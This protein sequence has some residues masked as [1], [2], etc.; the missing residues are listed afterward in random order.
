MTPNLSG[1]LLGSAITAIYAILIE[2]IKDAMRRK[3]E[4]KVAQ[5]EIYS[6]LADYLT[7]MKRIA[8]GSGD[9]DSDRSS[10]VR[11]PRFDAMDWYKSHRLDLLIRLDPSPKLRVL[12][13]SILDLHEHANDPRNALFGLPRAVLSVVDSYGTMIDMKYLQKR[14]ENMQSENVE[15]EDAMKASKAA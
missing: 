14:M 4:L 5:S 12:C 11:K 10:L 9:F 7:R 15:L 6:E 2:P 13:D 8:A 1:I 3:S